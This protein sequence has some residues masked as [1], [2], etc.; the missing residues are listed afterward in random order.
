MRGDT[1]ET[2]Y[3]IH[4]PFRH[5]FICFFFSTLDCKMN[6]LLRGWSWLRLS[7]FLSTCTCIVRCIDV[8][9]VKR[10]QWVNQSF[11]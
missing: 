4:L 7:F 6:A 2:G 3:L 10:R 8:T 5:S 11:C 9:A 1:T